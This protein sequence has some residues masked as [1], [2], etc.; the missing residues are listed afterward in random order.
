M[1]W[2]AFGFRMNSGIELNGTWL[3]VVAEVD[4]WN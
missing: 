4:K 3:W 1:I 2:M